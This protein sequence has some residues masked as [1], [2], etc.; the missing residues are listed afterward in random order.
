MTNL[1]KDIVLHFVCTHC[2][3]KIHSI[4]YT[5]IYSTHKSKVMITNGTRI[6]ILYMN[7]TASY[8][9]NCKIMDTFD[10]TSCIILHIHYRIYSTLV[11]VYTMI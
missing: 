11:H 7:N 6:Y 9:G 5:R 2:L 10:S 1:Y 8:P 3:F 4:T